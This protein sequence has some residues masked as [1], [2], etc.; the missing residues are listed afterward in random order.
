MMVIDFGSF[1]IQAKLS[2][3]LVNT[4]F[5]DPYVQNAKRKPGRTLSLGNRSGGILADDVI[6]ADLADHWVEGQEKIV[7][8]SY[9]GVENP[10]GCLAAE[11]CG[12]IDS[13]H[14]ADTTDLKTGPGFWF[15][16]DTGKY[17]E[18]INP[19]DTTALTKSN[20]PNFNPEGR[21]PDAGTGAAWLSIAHDW[22]SGTASGNGNGTVYPAV[23]DPLTFL[24]I[25]SELTGSTSTYLCDMSNLKGNLN[26][27]TSAFT[28]G[29]YGNTTLG[30]AGPF[31]L[32]GIDG[33][34]NNNDHWHRGA[35]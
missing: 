7:A 33:A 25:A 6:D 21:F 12:A 16:N 30:A 31:N 35:C 9:R 27:S 19:S 3:G 2:P 20:M 26:P 29:G 18:V 24:P 1:D 5:T 11:Y 17:G 13:C 23:F 22:L 32:F 8:C 10:Y 15:T 4:N 34:T 28:Y 14:T